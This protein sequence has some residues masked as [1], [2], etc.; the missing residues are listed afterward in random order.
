MPETERMTLRR[1][2][3]PDIDD[4]AA[5][6][7]AAEVAWDRVDAS[8]STAAQVLAEEMPRLMAHNRRDDKLGSWVARDRST[9]RFLGWFTVRPIESPVR[10]V[11]LSYRLLER[12]RGEGYDVEGALLMIAMARDAQ[13]STVVATAMPDD[14]EFDE[15][16]ERAGLRR[17]R[18]LPDGAADIVAEVSP[19]DGDYLLDLRVA[20]AS[21][22]P[23]G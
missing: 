21:S 23:G 10:T 17:I 9:G 6:A 11:E 1:T 18:T 3:W 22:G 8:A 16:M 19:S 20:A 12:T 14:M 13:V 7:A 4:V 5:L 15:V 2:N